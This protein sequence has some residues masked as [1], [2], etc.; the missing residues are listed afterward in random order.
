MITT[1]TSLKNQ[2]GDVYMPVDA[3]IDE[4]EKNRIRAYEN[5]RGQ[6][7]KSAAATVKNVSK[8][9]DTDTLGIITLANF[10]NGEF[11][12]LADGHGRTEGLLRRKLN[13]ELTNI[14][15]NS[16]VTLR[17][18]DKKDFFRHYIKLNTCKGH[19]GRQK[20]QNPDLFMGSIIEKVINL[21]GTE[22]AVIPGTFLQN[23]GYVIF[24][25][26]EK[27]NN[28]IDTIW[29]YA[30]VF[31]QR[32]FIEPLRNAPAAS[33][34]MKFNEQ[35]FIDVK[36]ALDF[37]LEYQ[38]LLQ[39]AIKEASEEKYGSSVVKDFNTILKSASF[40]GFLM[41]DRLGEQEV[42]KN[43]NA[44]FNGT[45]RNLRSLADLVTAITR[46]SEASIKRTCAKIIK[47]IKKY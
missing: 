19:T 47:V 16:M 10:N 36:E 11:F 42:T 22:E 43:V 31:G 14:E 15:K 35:V 3:Y 34:N 32:R 28:D 4:C 25:L 46:G 1:V 7:G 18:V 23:L 37:Y 33:L 13:N 27:P 26:A 8:N 5:N 39:T 44:L 29:D 41:T 40:F 21:Y 9:L 30:H 24:A 12:K 6:Q 20:D 2:L 38:K 17:I 45:K